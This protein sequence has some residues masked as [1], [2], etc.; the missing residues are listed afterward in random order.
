MILTLLMKTQVYAILMGIGHLKTKIL[1]TLFFQSSTADFVFSY[2]Y[3]K[4]LLGGN[5]FEIDYM[6][7]KI[8]NSMQTSGQKKNFRIRT[9]RKVVR[10]R[11][12]FWGRFSTKKVFRNYIYV[13]GNIYKFPFKSYISIPFRIFKNTRTDLF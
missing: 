4:S 1:N 9:P 5:L 10:K 3:K 7:E 13:A 8:Q 2:E 12:F 11:T 6:E